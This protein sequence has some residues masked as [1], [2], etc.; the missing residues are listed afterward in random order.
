MFPGGTI[1]GCPK[2]R[3]MEII[4][5]LEP[6]RRGIYTGSLGYID[7]RGD[8]DLNIVIRTLIL[9]GNKG[10]LQV[11]AGSSGIQT[12]KRIRRNPSQSRSAHESPG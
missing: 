8:L 9:K 1:T 6:V 5:E 2:I 4:D 12:R 3:C 7:L 10:Y 11:G